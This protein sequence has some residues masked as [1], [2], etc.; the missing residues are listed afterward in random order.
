M[1]QLCGQ[2]MAVGRVLDNDLN[3]RRAPVMVLDW[4]II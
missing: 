1:N 4:R 3:I 2:S